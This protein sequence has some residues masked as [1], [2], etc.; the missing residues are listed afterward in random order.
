MRMSDA[1]HRQTE[2]F[3]VV[4]KV[5]VSAIFVNASDTTALSPKYYRFIQWPYYDAAIRSDGLREAARLRDCAGSK[6]NNEE[7]LS[8]VGSRLHMD[9]SPSTPQLAPWQGAR[10]ALLQAVPSSRCPSYRGDHRGKCPSILARVL[11]RERGT[12][13]NLVVA[14]KLLFAPYNFLQSSRCF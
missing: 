3:I 5:A 12:L 6:R 11:E 9:A 8:A 2:I 4:M 13:H 7:A 10:A 14:K 1:A